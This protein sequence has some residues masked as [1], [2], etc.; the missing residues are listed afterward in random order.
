[1]TASNAARYEKSLRDLA[2]RANIPGRQDRNANIFQLV[3]NW[4]RDERIGKWILVLDNVDDDELLRK[5]LATSTEGQANGPSNAST[6][7]PLNYLLE[8]A[9][10]SIIAT[11]R[12]RGVALDIAGHKNLIAVQPMQKAEALGQH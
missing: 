7:P 8:N 10:G 2:D 4:L 3:G 11:S 6:Q 12:N 9:N 5:P 1:M